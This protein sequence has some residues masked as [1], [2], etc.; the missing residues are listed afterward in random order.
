MG[1]A[2]MVVAVSVAVGAIVVEPVTAQDAPPTRSS[3]EIRIAPKKAG[4]KKHPRG[5]TL[6]AKARWNTEPGLD[7][8]IV[9]GAELL[10]VKGI[11]FNGGR[12]PTCTKAVLR[13]E[14][15][16][17]C[18]KRSIVGQ[19]RSGFVEPPDGGTRAGIV[20]V[21][22]GQGRL[23]AYTTIYHPTLVQ[24]PV[25]LR[26]ERLTGRWSHRFGMTVPMNFQLV[27]DVPVQISEA[28]A[29]L[30]QPYAPSFVT[31]TSCPKGGWR[32]RMT[33]HYV[34]N[35]TWQRGSDTIKGR[36]PCEKSRARRSR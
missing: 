1:R 3:L 28:A 11:A 33:T 7:A 19:S 27:A 16:K 17:G 23:F 6:S 35:L 32:Y 15:P 13:L 4:T 36:V 14:G 8:P 22:G 24:E 9:T 31:T 2:Q 34:D 20:M 21:N 18:P 26:N 10:I 5:V 12:Y 30:G 25:E 29:K